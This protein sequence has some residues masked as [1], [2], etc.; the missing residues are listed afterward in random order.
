MKNPPFRRL[1]K[2][3]HKDAQSIHFD[4]DLSDEEV[5]YEITN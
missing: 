5:E 4:E 1:I 2:Q 3:V